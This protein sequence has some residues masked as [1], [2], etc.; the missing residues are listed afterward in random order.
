MKCEHQSMTHGCLQIAGITL[1]LQVMVLQS[2][3]CSIESLHRL[4]MCDWV[5]FKVDTVCCRNLQVAEVPDAHADTILH[6]I[7]RRGTSV[8]WRSQDD[9]FELTVP[10]S[11]TAENVKQRIE[12]TNGVPASSHR[13]LY[14]GQVRLLIRPCSA[15]LLA[16]CR[17][18]GGVRHSDVPLSWLLQ[19]TRARFRLMRLCHHCK[20]SGEHQSCCM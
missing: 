18:S 4:F 12:A 2:C 17:H 13:L 1:A 19:C 3:T 5:Y 11:A 20:G 15:I 6:L 8:A 9:Q 10:G 14:K 16:C 7:V